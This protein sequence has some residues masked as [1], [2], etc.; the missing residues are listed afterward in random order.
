MSRKSLLAIG[1]AMI[2]MSRASTGAWSMG[3]AGDT[4]NTAWYARALLGREAWDVEYYT[5]LGTDVYSGRM[6]EFMA[7][8]GLGTGRIQRDPA[9]RPGLYLIELDAGERSFTYWR[10]DSA[11]RALADDLEALGDAIAA[12]DAVYLSGITLAILP[13][14]RRGALVE[15]VAAATGRGALTAFDPNIR[16]VLWES[17]QASRDA[18]MRA[19]GSAAIVLPSFSDEAAAFGDA[20][21][22]ATMARYAAQGCAEVVVKNGA[23]PTL[24]A[25]AGITESVDI[26][27]I[28]EPVDTTGA[29]DAFNGGY[30][31]ARLRGLAPPDAAREG[32]RVAG[33]VVRRHGAIVPQADVAGEQPGPR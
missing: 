5:R 8:N 12:A 29:G 30:L 3:F 13:A 14:D 26:R 23:E 6:V 32:H 2:E 27:A 33:I 4:L 16:P 21:P 25:W 1:E 15:L 22:A 11:A 20:T 19:A 17:A 10:S 18:I 7:S 31:A 24:L 28:V 9:R